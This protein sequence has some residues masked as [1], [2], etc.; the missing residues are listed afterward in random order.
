MVS[1]EGAIISFTSS[2]VQCL[3]K[4]GEIGPELYLTSDRYEERDK[5]IHKQVM[6]FVQILFGQD[7]C[8]LGEHAVQKLCHA[9]PIVKNELTFLMNCLSGY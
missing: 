2:A 5:H 6:A 4:F 7:Q 1:T 3:P 9:V 8:E